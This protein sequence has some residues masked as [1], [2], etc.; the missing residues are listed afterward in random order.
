MRGECAEV[1]CGYKKAQR[2]LRLWSFRWWLYFP[3]AITIATSTA[4]DR[5]ISRQEGSWWRRSGCW[6]NVVVWRRWVAPSFLQTVWPW[7]EW[8]WS[9]PH[10]I[11]GRW[12]VSHA[13]TTS[14]ANK[15]HTQCKPEADTHQHKVCISHFC[16]SASILRMAAL[17]RLQ[18]SITS[19][20]WSE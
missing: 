3:S 8:W 16:L 6:L 11:H 18:L 9:W 2:L 20:N 1:Y 7:W 14:L 5:L 12:R 4:A 17:S 10:I 15:Y 19:S 13:T